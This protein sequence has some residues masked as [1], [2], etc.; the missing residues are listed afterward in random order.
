VSATLLATYLDRWNEQLTPGGHVNAY[1]GTGDR[2]ARPQWRGLASIDWSSGPW[3]ASYSAE[4]IGSYDE[5]VFWIPMS[6]A[7]FDSFLRQVEAALYHDFEAGYTFDA[8]LRV[9]AGVTNVTDEDPPFRSQHQPANTDAATYRLLGR[10][11]FLELRYEF[12]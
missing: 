2:G 7:E 3:L 1:A 10:T 5:R 6:G 4:Y 12:D 8:G 9:R 11:Y